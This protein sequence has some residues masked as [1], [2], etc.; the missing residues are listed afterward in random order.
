MKLVLLAAS[1]LLLLLAAPPPNLTSLLFMDSE[2]S[3]ARNDWRFLAACKENIE[4][5]G[6]NFNPASPMTSFHLEFSNY[7]AFKGEK[8]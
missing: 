1:A 5:E 8:L 7:A 2:A 4:K 3:F 6:L